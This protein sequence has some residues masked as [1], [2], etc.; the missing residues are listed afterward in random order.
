M[1]P[2]FILASHER[3]RDEIVV[4]HEFTFDR[5]KYTKSGK[6]ANKKRPRKHA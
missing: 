5:S 4:A 3:N 1:A 2:F 6:S